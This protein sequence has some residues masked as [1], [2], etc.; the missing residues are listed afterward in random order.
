MHIIKTLTKTSIVLT[1]IFNLSNNAY[2]ANIDNLIVAGKDIYNQQS[3][4]Y[5]NAVKT[6]MGRV[7]DYVTELFIK[8][9]G[10]V[11][12]TDKVLA[13][14]KDVNGLYTFDSKRIDLKTTAKNNSW[15]E[16]QKAPVHEIGHYIYH[17]AGI[18]FNERQK[19]DLKNLYYTRK[20]FDPR[21]YNEDETFAAV[22][23]DYIKFNYKGGEYVAPSVE[24]RIFSEAE[25]ICNQILHN[26]YE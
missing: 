4:T 24:Y 16:V 14:N 17:T 3:D 10:T 12:Y 2:A 22:Y 11:Q 7:P 6:Y 20:S 9:G 19:N 5:K 26:C 25:E 23:S 18:Y 15:D 8:Q 13:G 21:C 1:L